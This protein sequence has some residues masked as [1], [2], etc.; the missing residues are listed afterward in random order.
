MMPRKNKRKFLNKHF[1]TILIYLLSAS[2]SIITLYRISQSDYQILPFLT[3]ITS[4]ILLWIPHIKKFPKLNHLTFLGDYKFL[5]IISIVFSL[6]FI[7]LLLD[8]TNLFFHGDEAIGSRNAQT[9]F[10]LGINEQKWDLL[11]S[12]QG[13]LNQFPAL[14]YYV[15]GAIIYFL[16]PSVSTLKYFSFLTDIGI[17]FIIYKL[18]TWWWGKKFALGS[19][20]IYATLP[21]AIHYSMTGYQNIQPTFFMLLMIL[22][23][24]KN[25][26]THTKT[27]WWPLAAG[28]SAGLGM[29][30][31]LSS[32]LAPAIGLIIL[33]AWYIT[34][35]K[36]WLKYCSFFL[37]GYLITSAPFFIY[38]Y[39]EYNLLTE[40]SLVYELLL[41]ESPLLPTLWQQFTR[42]LLGFTSDHFNG[43]GLHYI[44]EPAIPGKIT[45]SLFII[46]LIGSII[47][48][49]RY[50]KE[51]FTL[52]FIFLI[53]ILTGGVLTIN[54][55]ASHRLIHLYP[56]FAL[57]ITLGS[58]YMYR[59]TLFV[60]KHQTIAYAIF[61]LCSITVTAS[62]LLILR[63]NNLPTYKQLLPI[64]YDF[65]H[66]YL[67]QYRASPL[68]I[69]I[70]IHSKDRIFYY[71]YGQIDPI[72]VNDKSILSNL[73]IHRAAILLTNQE[74][75][76]KFNKLDNEI[77]FS[78]LN[79]ENSENYTLYRIKYR[80]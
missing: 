13:T 10:E 67:T 61:I 32:V 71:S 70:P 42:I 28:V 78:N 5:L 3:W 37:I 43:D 27:V 16:G 55:P 11:G 59:V 40:R 79:W 49:K 35:P 4:I 62:N 41:K 7:Y 46:G 21:I 68:F 17:S 23:L 75:I 52:W 39:F 26:R 44:Y 47:F 6:R 51:T 14:W 80:E 12:K 45:F 63:N 77:Q 58:Y 76:A 69:H 24:E 36:S 72:P 2:L 60:T 48:Y 29:Y 30:F 57:F 31:Y 54:P 20:I 1:Y 53:T 38:S 74:G 22:F 50:L 8:P 15:Q 9:A 66:Y 65:A 73:G 25:R 33:T 34:R 64:E 19:L 56:I 18:S